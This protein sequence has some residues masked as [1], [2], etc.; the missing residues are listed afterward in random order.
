MNSAE[1]AGIYTKPQMLTRFK[2]LA[3]S[4]SHK[5]GNRLDLRSARHGTAAVVSIVQVLFLL[6]SGRAKKN[7]GKMDRLGQN[8]AGAGPFAWLSSHVLWSKLAQ[9]IKPIAGPIYTSWIALTNTTYCIMAIKNATFEKGVVRTH[10]ED[11]KLQNYPFN[12]TKKTHGKHPF[13]IQKRNDANLYRERLKKWQ[14]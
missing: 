11:S 7:K 12:A 2:N 9:I 5:M 6:R 13:P 3:H 1:T 10:E 4:P 8:R 14:Q